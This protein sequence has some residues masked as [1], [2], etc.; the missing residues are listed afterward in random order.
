MCTF[1]KRLLKSVSSL[2]DD[3]FEKPWLLHWFLLS[4]RVG[5]WEIRSTIFGLGMQWSVELCLKGKPVDQIFI[6]M[7]I[8]SATFYHWLACFRKHGTFDDETEKRNEHGVFSSSEELQNVP[9]IEVN[10]GL[11]LNKFF[12]MMRDMEAFRTRD[13]SERTILRIMHRYGFKRTNW[14]W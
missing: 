9:K 5:I 3:I 13:F 12:E 4:L 7:D 14:S 2:H 6:C 1:V 10:S 8:G 11:M